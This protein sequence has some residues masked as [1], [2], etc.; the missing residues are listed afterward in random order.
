MLTDL[1]QHVWTPELVEGLVFATL[2]G[3]ATLRA[4]RFE[5]RS[6]SPIDLHDPLTFYDVSSYGPRAVAA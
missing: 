1:H 3:C 6:G 4:K 2:A 5:Q